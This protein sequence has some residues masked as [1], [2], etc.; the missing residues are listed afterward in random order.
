MERYLIKMMGGDEFK[1]TEEEYKEIMGKVGLIY[2]RSSRKTINTASIS[3]IVPERV[4]EQE[5]DRSDQREG[6]LHDGTRVIRY[7]GSWYLDGDIGENGKPQ[8]IIDPNYYP[9]IARDCVP[10]PREFF[11]KYEMLPREERLKLITQGTREPRKGDFIP[12]G[13]LKGYLDGKQ[14]TQ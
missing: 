7:F 11:E 4:Y 6:I 1:I 13:D 3:Y 9:E 2:I 10:T 5:I 12:I 8:R 14:I